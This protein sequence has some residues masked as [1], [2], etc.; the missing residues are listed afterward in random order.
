[1]ISKQS[2]SMFNLMEQDSSMKNVFIQNFYATTNPNFRLNRLQADHPWTHV[3]E[4]QNTRYLVSLH[5]S[6]FKSAN[7][8]IFDISKKGQAKKIY[9]PET[10]F[11]GNTLRFLNL[12]K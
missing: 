3:K 5:H 12:F 1:M 2:K 6:Y 10:V 4:I 8:E 7:M 9:T 11:G